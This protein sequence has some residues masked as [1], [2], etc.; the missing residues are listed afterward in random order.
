MIKV[1]NIKTH[2][3]HTVDI[4]S[5]KIDVQVTDAELVLVE[6]KRHPMEG[7]LYRCDHEE[8]GVR[9][10]WVGHNTYGGATINPI[11]ISKTEKIEVGDWVY[12]RAGH[13]K[14]YIKEFDALAVD[15]GNCSDWCVK[16][17]AL[18]DHFSPEQ[19]QDI[20]DGKLKEGKYL[21]EC[22]MWYKDI[23][24]EH[25]A[26]MLT[27]TEYPKIKLNPHITIYPVEERKYS[28]ED[29]R[30]AMKYAS[31]HLSTVNGI[32][33]YLESLNKNYLTE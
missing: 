28:E 26:L 25:K 22:E 2:T 4:N 13:Q 12:D 20:V 21:L 33:Q 10:F 29:M 6:C 5:R 18:P 3:Q 1:K 23:T 8:S 27:G 31:A 15:G 11:F 32:N 14:V 30:L 17:L 9:M 24:G 16:I 19:L 7:E